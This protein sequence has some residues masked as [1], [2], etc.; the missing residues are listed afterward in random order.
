MRARD[1]WWE[2]ARDAATLLRERFHFR[3][4]AVIGD[5]VQPQPLGFWSRITI[6]V[7]DPRTKGLPFELYDA[8]QNRF[9]DEPR[10]NIVE[11]QHATGAEERAI[12]TE[13]VEI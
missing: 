5:L 10:I 12:E 6:V 8:L 2:V 13:A 1:H 3:K 11:A 9:Q 4:L 7:S